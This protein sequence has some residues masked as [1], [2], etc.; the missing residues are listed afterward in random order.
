MTTLRPSLQGSRFI[1]HTD[2]ASPRWLLEISEPSGRFKCW[3]VR[4]TE[5]YF[6]VRFKKGKLTSQADAL[7][8]LTTLVEMFVPIG[9]KIPC[10]IANADVVLYGPD[11]AIV[12]EAFALQDHN[13]SGMILSPISQ[14]ELSHEK[15]ADEL[16]SAIR[17]GLNEGRRYRSF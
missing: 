8:R 15:I 6:E 12:A 3:R 17:Q 7:P 5:F 13:H 11:I 1:V 4:L 9:N 14:E 10:F 16:R 2:H